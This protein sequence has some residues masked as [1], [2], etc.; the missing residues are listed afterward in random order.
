MRLATL[1]AVAQEYDEGFHLLFPKI[2]NIVINVDWEHLK[3]CML[4]LES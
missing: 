3:V 2:S 1:V 4:I